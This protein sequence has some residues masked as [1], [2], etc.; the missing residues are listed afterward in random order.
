MYF[1]QTRIGRTINELRK[2]TADKSL[3][4]RAKNLVRRW[5]VLITPNSTNSN[6]S[7]NGEGL[8]SG[9]V[10]TPGSHLLQHVLKG[11]KSGSKPVSPASRPSTPHSGV[12]SNNSSPALVRST[13]STP[14]PPS[15]RLSPK[16]SASLKCSNSAMSPA[17][18]TST[19]INS[20]TNAKVRVGVLVAET[21]RSHQPSSKS[22]Q[23]SDKA[24][25]SKT[26]A[27]NK[28]RKRDQDNTPSPLLPNKK[29]FISD[30][31]NSRTNGTSKSKSVNGVAVPSADASNGSTPSTASDP[32]SAATY[33]IRKNAKLSVRTSLANT[34]AD[35][36]S[37]L[38]RLASSSVGSDR[39][40]K[41]TPQ[42]ASRGNKV[43]TTA[44]L[45][46]DLA[47]RKEIK[48]EGSETVAKI[49]QNRIE[50]EHEEVV[51][52][53]PAGAMP[54]PRKT[55]GSSATLPNTSD[56]ALSKTKNEMV[57]KFLESSVSASQTDLSTVHFN[58]VDSPSPLLQDASPV[59][60]SNV[61]SG[62]ASLNSLHDDASAPSR[63]NEPVKET[64]QTEASTSQTKETERDP[65]VIY[66]IQQY[67]H[68]SDLSDKEILHRVAEDPLSLLPP[69]SQPQ[70][71]LE[72]NQEKVQV[73]S[74]K[75][76]T[77]SKSDI[78][79]IRSDKWEGVNGHR[80]HQHNWHDWTKTCSMPTYNND[81]LHILPYVDIDINDTVTT[82]DKN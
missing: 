57:R 63:I 10:P 12:P 38:E 70:A 30:N 34:G 51:S 80:D 66:L 29:A 56:Q 65:A 72:D 20:A 47:T 67:P 9:K 75:P 31:S 6:S 23:P 53:V 45:L 58:G 74:P 78:Q 33:A 18:A 14:A 21:P 52:I 27:A 48:L 17:L 46:Q 49:A 32:K 2:K 68:I 25:L 22:V 71:K 36:S 35:V 4:K 60:S 37:P 3:A 41:R 62:R 77:V 79:R 64:V 43:K 42:S 26:Y 16:A 55:P 81:L 7:L 44:Q 76:A 1:Q 39:S 15:S 50:K 82:N 54:R 19:P 69:S 24:A 28:K 61:D 40:D 73:P 59:A 11:E 8:G 5:Q 13:A